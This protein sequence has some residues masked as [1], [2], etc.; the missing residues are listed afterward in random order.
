M[1]RKIAERLAAARKHSKLSQEEAATR[2]GVS[3]QTLSKWENGDGMPDSEKLILIADLYNL[4]LD[5]LLLGRE[6]RIDS[7]SYEQLV[8]EYAAND[9]YQEVVE[10][11]LAR[12][13]EESSVLDRFI[14]YFPFP[15]LCVALFLVLGFAYN[16]WK[17]CWTVFLAIP[18][19]YITMRSIKHKNLVATIYPIICTVAYIVLGFVA[20]HGWE[21]GWVLLFSVPL[22]NSIVKAIQK[23]N[24]FYFNYP[25]L[26]LMCY[27]FMGLWK[28]WWHPNWIVFLTVPLYYGIAKIVEHK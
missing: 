11:Y 9:S 6:P 23:K 24:F 19:Y 7:V 5:V 10:D 26:I 27:L 12:T 3:R 25:M 8:E 1:D 4:S 2:L 21:Y 13:G 28:G 20:P 22:Y 16:S 15:I 17:V 14:R 18:V